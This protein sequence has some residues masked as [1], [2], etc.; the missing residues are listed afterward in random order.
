[1]QFAKAPFEFVYPRDDP[2]FQLRANFKMK[3]PKLIVGDVFEVFCFHFVLHLHQQRSVEVWDAQIR[4]SAEVHTL[5][6][7]YVVLTLL[8]SPVRYGKAAPDGDDFDE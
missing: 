3:R 1:M 7:V 5:P 8:Y 2:L 4:V 6:I